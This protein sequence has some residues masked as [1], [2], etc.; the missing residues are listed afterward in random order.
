[1]TTQ[2]TTPEDEPEDDFGERPNNA[3]GATWRMS[4]AE[5][6]EALAGYDPKAQ[7]LLYWAFQY[8]KKNLVSINEFAAELGISG[9]NL[10]KVLRGV[11]YDPRDRLLP[12]EEQR[13]LQP[14]D[15]LIEAIE[16]LR[17]LERRRVSIGETEF[18]QTPSAQRIWDACDMTRSSNMMASIYGKS[19]VG[20]TWALLA[21][22]RARGF[23]NTLYIRIDA[24]TTKSKL[25]ADI[26]R[27]LGYRGRY[28]TQE[29]EESI[30]RSLRG[31]MLIIFDELH[32]LNITTHHVAKYQCLEIMRGLHDKS[33]CGV[34]LCGTHIWR[35]EFDIGRDKGL[36]EQIER[37]SILQVEMGD[38]VTKADLAAI[39][40]AYDLAYPKADDAKTIR[41]VSRKSGLKKITQI[42]RNGAK[43]ALKQ[44]VRLEWRHVFLAKDILENFGKA[45]QWGA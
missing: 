18:V 35:N 17:E 14:S 9:S 31:D 43:L 23:D 38:E 5:L 28:K 41:E 4:A 15:K 20:K 19:H 13:L 40:A 44:G 12:K 3:V 25:V 29:L 22:Q 26:G 10:S 8:G 24:G 42:L 6:R 7:E 16:Q 27:T 30:V 32:Q 2:A 1:M 11:N 21:Y 36:L 33:G 39:F 34:V 37:R 45:P